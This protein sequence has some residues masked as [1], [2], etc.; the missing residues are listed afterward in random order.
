MPENCTASREEVI[1]C[2]I[3]FV[4][5]EKEG[6]TIFKVLIKETFQQHDIAI[7][8]QGRVK[9]FAMTKNATSKTIPVLNAIIIGAR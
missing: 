6:H 1:L 5:H 2:M 8:I 3:T 4:R 9:R 7:V